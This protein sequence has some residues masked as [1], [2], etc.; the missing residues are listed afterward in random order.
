ML[1]CKVLQAHMFGEEFAVTQ[2]EMGMARQGGHGHGLGAGVAVP[3]VEG[4][5]AGATGFKV[6]G[7]VAR[8][9]AASPVGRY[10]GPRWPQPAL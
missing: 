2:R 4:A 7:K 1:A 3:V 6:C 10:K 5:D 9:A 8:P